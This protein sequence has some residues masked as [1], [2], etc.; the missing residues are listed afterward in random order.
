M[1]IFRPNELRSFL[2]EQGAAALKS[3]SQNFLID[4]NIVKKIVAAAKISSND[5]CIE[6][7]PGPG[8]L[9]EAMLQAG[10]RVI[11]IEK[12]RKFPAALTRFQTNDDRLTV[13]E[14]DALTIDLAK[15]LEKGGCRKLVSNL[16][17]HLTTPLITR[18]LPLHQDLESITVMVQKEVAERFTAKPGTSGASSISLF[19]RLF[20]D[21]KLCFDV[22]PSCFYPRPKVTSSVIH[23]SLKKPPE[24][25]DPE[26]FEYLARTAFQQRRKMLR[27]SLKES[28]PPEKLQAAFEKSNIDPSCRP[29]EL[30]FEAFI[31]FYRNLYD[32]R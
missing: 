18:F 1:G 31:S 10:A 32:E 19:V 16:P 22:P 29:E 23:L 14:D 21:P 6:V 30:T 3:L 7:G 2:E 20:S 28:F 9:T 27:S 24:G 8:A 4:G 26:K 25:I 12:D 5:I 11:A 17:Y 13:Y 15:L